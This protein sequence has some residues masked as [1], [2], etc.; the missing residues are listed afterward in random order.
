MITE[1]IA[2]AILLCPCMGW[3]GPWWFGYGYWFAS[4]MFIIGPILLV[5]F[6]ALIVL[7]IVWLLRQI[8]RS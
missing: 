1:A 7:L 6:M 2:L 8:M 5:L 4:P 3:W